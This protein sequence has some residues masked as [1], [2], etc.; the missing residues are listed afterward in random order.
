MEKMTTFKPRSV[1]HFVDSINEVDLSKFNR[2]RLIIGRNIL[3]LNLVI[4]NLYLLD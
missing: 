4:M 1:N 3:L 2:V